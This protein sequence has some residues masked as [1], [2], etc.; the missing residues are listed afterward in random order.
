[1]SIF[2][3]VALGCLGIIFYLLPSVISS[4]RNCQHDGRIFF[5]NLVFGWT[6]I[7]WMIA[8]FWALVEAPERKRFAPAWTNKPFPVE[9]ENPYATIYLRDDDSRSGQQEF[10]RGERG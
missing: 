1:M 8:L 2:L 4:F 5:V 10:R 3:A 7:G 6:V 9:D